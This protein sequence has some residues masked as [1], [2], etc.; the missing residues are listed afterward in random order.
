M[1]DK[2][3]LAPWNLAAGTYEHK[4]RCSLLQS[5]RVPEACIRVEGGPNVWSMWIIVVLSRLCQR[6]LEASC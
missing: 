3:R 2:A 6:D 1:I 4:A 5:W